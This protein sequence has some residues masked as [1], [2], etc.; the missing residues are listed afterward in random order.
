MKTVNAQPRTP[1][2]PGEGRPD[3]VR[4]NDVIEMPRNLG[5]E[6]GDETERHD[7][8]LECDPS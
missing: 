5:P 8:E 1:S 3:P 6:A 2:R 4:Y 7:Q